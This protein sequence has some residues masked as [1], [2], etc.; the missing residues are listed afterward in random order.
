M[1]SMPAALLSSPAPLDAPAAYRALQTHDVRF[2]GRLYVGVTSTGIYCRPVCRVKLPRQENCRF[3]GNAALA[4]QAG[5]R[6]CL[7]CRP[8]LAP[9]L[10]RTDSSQVLAQA[11]ARWIEHAV[12]EGEAPALPDI[13]ARLGVTDRHFRRVFQ[14]AHGV[15]PMAWLATQRLLLAK[16]LLTDTQL[17]V[18]EVAAA[19]G[20]ASLRRFNAAFAGHYRLAPTALRRQAGAPSGSEPASVRLPWRPPYDSAAMLAFLAA[21]P[22]PGV[23]AV[24]DQRWQRTLALMH[25][26]RRCTGWLTLHFDDARH[27]VRAQV[28]PGLAPALGAL[29]QRLR[30]LLD[31]DTDMAEIDRVLADLPGGPRPGQRVPGCLDGFETTVRIILGQQVTVAAACTLAARLVAR[32]GEPLQTG[33]PGLDRLFP[34]PEALATASAEAIGVLGIVR[35]RVAAIQSLAQAVHQGTLALHPA[36]PMAA[37]LQALQAL[38]GIGAWTAELVALRVLAWPDAFPAT[39]AGVIKALGGL[40]PPASHALAEPWRPW[41]SYAVTRLWHSLADTAADGAQRASSTPPDTAPADG[42]DHLVKHRARRQAPRP[43]TTPQDFT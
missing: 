23:E 9:G 33:T 8:E 7:R 24:V 12:A 41:R 6:P 40:R 28:S 5:F 21:R 37:T 18:T 32:F 25:H 14:A 35:S 31:L 20:F 15:S 3:F 22:L 11:G 29:V 39:D 34:T 19:S 4:E 42:G 13:A 27:E 16:R 38:P 30:H 10:S 43:A 17:P 1:A 26:G 36:A 2:D